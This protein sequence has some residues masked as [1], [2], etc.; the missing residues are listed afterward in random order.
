MEEAD[1]AVDGEDEAVDG[2]G[3]G[4]EEPDDEEELTCTMSGPTR[5]SAGGCAGADTAGRGFALG[6]DRLV[7]WVAIGG[8]PQVCVIICTHRSRARVSGCAGGV[9]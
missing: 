5:H 7:P 8:T 1:E 3:N 4:E 6:P 9:A 2:E